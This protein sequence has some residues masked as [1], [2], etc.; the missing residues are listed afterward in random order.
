MPIIKAK[1]LQ[2]TAL[3]RKYI[4]QTKSPIHHNKGNQLKCT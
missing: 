1:E 2:N 3:A 4:G